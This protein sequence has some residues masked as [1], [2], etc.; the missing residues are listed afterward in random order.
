MFVADGFNLIVSRDDS[1]SY[2]RC[3]TPYPPAAPAKAFFTNQA[4]LPYDIYL[5]DRA[6]WKN[7]PQRIWTYTIGGYPVIKKWLSYRAERVL[8]RPLRQTELV[9]VVHMARRIA[10]IA[11]MEP[12]LDANYVA[13]KTA[14]NPW[15]NP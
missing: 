9:E 6:Y 1:C 10:A 3:S 14:P 7:I 5:N 15:P 13:V 11:L 12:D 4:R 2:A 8:G